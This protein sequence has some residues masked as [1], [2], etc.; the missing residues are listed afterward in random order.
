MRRERLAYFLIALAIYLLLM[1]FSI[2][3]TAPAVRTLLY[4]S[5]AVSLLAG[6]VPRVIAIPLHYAYPLKRVEY[7]TFFLSIC[8]FIA[9]LL[10]KLYVLW[11]N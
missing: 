11:P 1:A 8:F 4:V 10:H 3:Q 6:N 9:L 7:F 2:Y 5:V